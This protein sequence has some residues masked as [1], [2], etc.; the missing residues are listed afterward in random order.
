MPIHPAM[1]GPELLAPAGG[2][3]A[4]R[5]AIAN[6]ADAVYLG[7][8]DLNA[9]R[10]AEN[11]TMESLGEW[12]RWAHLR[13]ARVYLTA[14]VVVLPDELDGALQLVAGA[15][16]AGVDA[17][18]VQDLGFL[19]L[20][21][22]VLP[23]VRIHCSTQIDAHNA[24]AV[25]ALA[26][27]GASRVTLARELSVDEVAGLSRHAAVE[28][29]S[30]VHGSL[31]FCHSGQCLMSSMIGGRSANR[32]LCA[33]P[34]RLPYELVADDG[35]VAE[36][37][38]RYLLSPADLA[39]VTRLP[40][41]VRSGVSALKIEGRMKSA[42]YVATVVRVYRATIDRVIAA[43]DDFQV[44]DGEWD[45]LSEAFSRGFSEAYLSD[46][47]DDRMMSY[48][49]PNNRGVAVGR[50]AEV[51]GRMATITFERA[52]EAGDTLEFWTGSGRFAQPAA[53]L[54]HEGRPAP[55]VPAGGRAQLALQ[56]SVRQGDRVFR[57]A[58][59]ALLE[60]ARR[61]FTGHEEHR[62][63]DADFSVRL[64]AGHPALVSVDCEGLSASVEGPQVEPARTR[65]VSA[66]EIVEHVGRLGGTPY[67]AEAW[68]IDLDPGVGISF[69]TLHRLRREV[70]DELDQQRLEPWAGRSLPQ[71]PAVPALRGAGPSAAP[72]PEVVVA[73]SDPDVAVACERAGADRIL[74]AVTSQ[75]RPRSVPAGVEPLLPRVVHEREMPRLRKTA[76][77]GAAT[78]GN[79]GTLAALAPGRGSDAP[80]GA[81]WGLNTVNAWTAAALA[82]LGAAM[83]W[84]SPELSGRQLAALVSGS[85]V[86][87]GALVHGRVELMV[88]EHCV[89]Q[90]AGPCDHACAQCARRRGR[91]HLR[92]RKGYQFPV[93]TDSAGR[94]HVYNS[95]PMDL[96]RALDEVVE[97][98]VAAIR[99]DLHVET[100]KEAARIVERYRQLLADVAA[101]KRMPTEPLSSPSTAGHFFRGVG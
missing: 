63:V 43:P 1:S 34:C 85:P 2:P 25:S 24:A 40:D 94:T 59:A 71:R 33:Q 70:L 81:D 16:S 79:L 9:R 92:D 83:V 15:W 54:S 76:G 22:E 87:V 8:P 30:F 72:V 26:R 93:S 78:C 39:G 46:I 32:G 64:L 38:G 5:A 95:V 45:L 42:E 21:R 48:G 91:W 57:V 77:D 69:S 47:R 51:H 88:A 74:F 19:R 35:T 97:T 68:R 89:L 66:E 80:V 50:V 4:L 90:A 31:C 100:P 7:L 73:V 49:R 58:N 65:A 17:V 96:T 14:N 99:L 62:P 27:M 28:L 56:G 44:T 55:A 6:G 13:G 41:L 12:T 82:D 60:A 23:D 18:I 61:T 86:P 37:P 84:A 101:G 3:D 67:R 36:T 52:V 11:F 20:L 98:G 75:V 29:E 53:G 10:G